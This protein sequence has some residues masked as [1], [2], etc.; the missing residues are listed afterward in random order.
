LLLRILS[1]ERESNR[2]TDLLRTTRKYDKDKNVHGGIMATAVAPK[3]FKNYINGEWVET[4]GGKA[5][6]NHNPANTHDLVG[7]FPAST[8]EDV[9]AAF[10]KE[11][12]IPR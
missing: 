7:I 3:T 1:N 11:K 9:T 6:E 5:I 2:Y 10:A 4:R 12:D 8:A